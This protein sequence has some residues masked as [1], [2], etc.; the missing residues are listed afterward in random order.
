[1]TDEDHF[2]HAIR[3]KPDDA[4][5]RLVYADWLDERGDPRGEYLRLLN[6]LRELR[7]TL[8]PEWQR[9][10]AEPETRLDDLQ[11][12][13]GRRISL[14]EL[15]QFSVYAGLLEGY[16]NREMNERIITRLV[17]EERERWRTGQEPYLI[18]PDERPM[19]GGEW[20]NPRLGPPVSLPSLACVGTFRCSD[21]ARDKG[22]DFSELVVIWFQDDFGPPLERNLLESLRV[23][24]WNR[25]AYDEM[26]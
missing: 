7:G 15:R 14:R 23:I 26:Y 20:V 21:P 12:A 2:L 16:P 8:D 5:T 25:H 3:R 10:V 19:T 6:R 17:E 11:L 18:R 24:D 9:S 4:L 1:M 13:S 22:S